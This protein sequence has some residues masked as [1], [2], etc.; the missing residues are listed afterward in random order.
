MSS[1]CFALGSWP[2]AVQRPEAKGRCDKPLAVLDVEGPAHVA[3]LRHLA[4][5]CDDGQHGVPHR[6]WRVDCI[7]KPH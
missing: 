2:P 5:L 4:R 6:P 3:R 7:G 1:F